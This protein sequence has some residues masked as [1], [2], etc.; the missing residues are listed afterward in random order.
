MP[1]RHARD[2]SDVDEAAPPARSIAA[3]SARMA[4]KTPTRFTSTTRAKS[5]TG[6]SAL[7]AKAPSTPAAL[8]ARSS[9]GRP[10][11]ASAT[12]PSSVTSHARIPAPS[13]ASSLDA[14]ALSRASRSVRPADALRRAGDDRDPLLETAH[15]RPAARRRFSAPESLPRERPPPAGTGVPMAGDYIRDADITHLAHSKPRLGGGTMPRV[16]NNELRTWPRRPPSRNA[17]R[18]LQRLRK[19]DAGPL[20]AHGGSPRLLP[21]LLPEARAPPRLARWRRPPLLS[22]W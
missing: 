10:A 12:R 16:D 8:T 21:R 13:R 6:A 15:E 7:R 5:S 17:Q 22:T 14:A 11:N 19:G 3:S 4:R 20:Q 18:D 9:R 1:P 2:R